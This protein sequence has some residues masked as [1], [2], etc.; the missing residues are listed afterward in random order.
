MTVVITLTITIESFAI[1]QT[2]CQGVRTAGAAALDL[3]YVAAGRLDAIGNMGIKIWI[4]LLEL[5]IVEEAGG[6]FQTMIR[7][8]GH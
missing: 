3:C 4:W 6:R 2:R 5:S 8:M 7:A 1:L